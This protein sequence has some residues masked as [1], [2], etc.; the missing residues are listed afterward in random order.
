MQNGPQ[1]FTNLCLS[2]MKQ[3][4]IRLYSGKTLLSYE[5]SP[6]QTCVSQTKT[7]GIFLLISARERARES[8]DFNI[9]VVC[10][11][12]GD[13]CTLK[14]FEKATGLWRNGEVKIC[15][16][17]FYHMSRARMERGYNKSTLGMEPHLKTTGNRQG[18]E[19]ANRS[20]LTTSSITTVW[21]Y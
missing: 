20:H 5:P 11:P 8:R 2:P 12:Q 14:T 6:H 15:T 9:M 4:E 17:S 19:G 1:G 13:P 21:L 16:N 3:R 7:S 10:W 18:N